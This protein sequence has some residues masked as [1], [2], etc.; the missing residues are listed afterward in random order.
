M[1]L[2]SRKEGASAPRRRSSPPSQ[3]QAE[4]LRGRARQ[5]LI[6][7]LALVVAAVIVVPLLIQTEP[8]PQR[9]TPIVVP[10]VPPIPQPS[11]AANEPLSMDQGALSGA[12]GLSVETPALPLSQPVA[13]T[14]GQASGAQSEAAAP[15]ATTPAAAAP[16]VQ[17]A[18]AKPEPKPEATPQPPAK[19]SASARTDDGSVAIA[20]L[21]GRS[22][23]RPPAAAARGNF[24]VQIAA[25]ST[26]KDAEVR[27]DALVSAGV[28]NA[29]VEPANP[30]GK[31]TYRLRV[32]PFPTREAAQAAQTRLR[33]LDYVNSF[34]APQ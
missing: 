18:A 5:R 3:A 4:D 7:A 26:Q 2:F 25:Y 33:S 12:N 24:V 1:G 14:P 34:I 31:A 22:P 16:A 15:A 23:A 6:G 21:E 19:P 11:I 32:G 20:L 8:E 27:R 30:D 29:Y 28:S 13:E 17:E 10:A 9:E